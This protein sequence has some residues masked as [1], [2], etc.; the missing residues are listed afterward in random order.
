MR[1][2]EVN[3]GQEVAC[4]FLIA[5]SDTAKLFEAI[6]EA[7]NEMTLAVGIPIIG[8]E[9][10]T[11]FSRRDDRLRA[12]GFDVSDKW[13]GVIAFVGNHLLSPKPCNKGGALRDVM[14]LAAGKLAAQR[15]AQRIHRHMDLG[16]QPAARSSDRL[17][18]LF[19][20]APAAC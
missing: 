4:E 12:S 8:T 10:A 14:C 13:G 17:F 6:E 3:H 20:W 9:L 19:F 7:F 11:R 5:G 2:G 15:I 1:G 16:A 18:P